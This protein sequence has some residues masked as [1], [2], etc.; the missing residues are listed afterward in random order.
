MP[1]VHPKVAEL[2]SRR[3]WAQRTPEWYAVRRTLLTASDV[4]GVLD[5]K[6]FAS[7]KGS[8]REDLMKRKLD[9]HPFGNMYTAH[10]QK[11]EDE[12]RALM[13]ACLGETVREYGLLLHPTLPWLA[14]SPDGVTTSGKCVEIKCPMRRAIVPGHVPEHYLP[15]V[16]TQM[17]VC[18][19]DSTLFVQYR[20][21]VMNADGKPFIDIAV[22]ERDPGF[23]DRHALAL[24]SFYDAY[25]AALPT[26]VPAPYASPTCSVV[27]GLYGPPVGPP[28]GPPPNRIGPP[29]GA[30]P[31]ARRCSVVDGM[32]S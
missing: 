26:H 4:A 5:V 11:Y 29:V 13:E 6:P 3:Q 7:Y 31:L 19:V 17:A 8:P 25:M 14:A 18:D 24:K 27:S 1:W 15:Q 32:Y 12:A 16:Q 20:P 23:L 28:V 30:P 21:A 2:D 9:N 10:G 22:V